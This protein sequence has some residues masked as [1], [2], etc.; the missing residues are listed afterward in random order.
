MRVTRVG[1]MLYKKTQV[2]LL[3]LFVFWSFHLVASPLSG[4]KK[5]GEAKLEILFWDVYQSELYTLSGSYNKDIF[6]QALKIHYLRNIKAKDLLE[7]TEE[8]WQKLGVSKDQMAPW[9]QKLSTIWP[10]IN[11]GDEL[12]VIVNDTGSSDFYFNQKT[13]GTV[14]YSDFGQQ[15]LRIWLDEKCSYPKLQKRLIGEK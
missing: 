9:I 3:L 7:R 5:V 12:L 11:K 14:E 6:P 13:I 4:F 2:S 10:N 8:E 15:F 1:L